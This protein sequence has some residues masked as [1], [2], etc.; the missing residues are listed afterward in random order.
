MLYSHNMIETHAFNSG[1][2]PESTP[3]ISAS[4]RLSS[5]SPEVQTA[6]SL[7]VRWAREDDRQ[8]KE[9]KRHEEEHGY[10]VARAW[11]PDRQKL[12]GGVQMLDL[13]EPLPD[14]QRWEDFIRSDLTS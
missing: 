4:E 10:T 14:G 13:I 11:T 5:F 2:N 8:V 6:A 3:S 1:E 9:Q 7:L 12:H